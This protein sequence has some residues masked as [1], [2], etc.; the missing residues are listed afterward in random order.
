MRLR[1]LN[2]DNSATR[3]VDCYL[4]SVDPASASVFVTNGSLLFEPVEQV[5]KVVGVIEF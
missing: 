4:P 3:A 2:L 1:G 5:G